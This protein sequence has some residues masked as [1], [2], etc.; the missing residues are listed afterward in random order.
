MILYKLGSDAG[1]KDIKSTLSAGTYCL[2]DF[3]SKGKTATR[4]TKTT[5]MGYMK[6]HLH[7]T[8]TEIIITILY[9]NQ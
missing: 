9:T 7:I 3:N 4:H 1:V 5:P 6:Y 2:D 8:F